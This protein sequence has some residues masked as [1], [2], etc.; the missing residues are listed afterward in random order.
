[1]SRLTRRTAL[2]LASGAAAAPLIASIPAFAQAGRVHGLS[3]FGDLKYPAGF[4]HFD[5]VNPDAP[6]GGRF[7]FQ[8]PNWTYNQ[9]PQTFNTMNSFVSKSDAP[10]RM[11]MTFDTLMVRAVDEP[12][13]LYGLVAEAIEVSEYG[14][15]LRFFLRRQ[16]RFHDGSPLTAKDV[17]FS[18]NIL[19]TEGHPSI[20][21]S[22][23]DM[24]SAEAVGDHEIVV[25][26]SGR[27]SSALKLSIGALPIF[28]ATYYDGRD[29]ADS[30]MEPPLGSGPY[31]VG[32]FEAGRFIEYER[33]EDYWARDLPAMRGMNNFDIIRV[34]FFRDRTTGFE[35]FKKGDI[36]FRQEFTSKVW[37]TE[38]VF[39]AILDGRA[40]KMLVPAEKRPSLQSWYIN[41]RREKFADPRTREAIGLA[42]DFEWVNKNLFYGLYSRSG[43]FFEKSVYAAD[44]MPSAEELVLLEPWRDQLP[45]AV[46]EEPYRP[47]VSDGSGR[48]RTHLRKAVRL[49][50][51]AGWARKGSKLVN[52]Q[53]EPLS[54]EF[55]I[56]S[57]TFERVLGKYVEALRSIGVEA[58]IR[59]VDPAQYQTRQ[60]D[61]DFDII[62]AAFSL[63]ATPMEELK[64]SLTSE[65][66]DIPGSHNFAAIR[67]PVVDALIDK[68]LAAPDRQTHRTAL[69]AID[70]V[71]RAKHYVIPEW[72]STDHRVA[73]WDMFGAPEIK[74]DYAFPVETTWWYDSDKAARI[75]K[76][77]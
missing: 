29:F 49:L 14:N 77:Q 64:P 15:E 2:K 37:A 45:R 63:S 65:A 58:M 70:R 54:V 21:L 51:E 47:P 57:P 4:S 71:L 73:L 31:R 74:P 48:D 26:L 17:A 35:A 61:F 1:L 5:Y 18:F 62:S 75:G 68:A 3:I 6:K 28:S 50:G 22:L 66:A 40:K 67:E 30:T 20:S 34:E 13:S 32:D 43:S 72:F 24:V 53:G 12:D 56:R 44:G 36:T 9:N 11:E 7:V 33:V 10:P 39:P 60:N 19:K 8:V 42:F 27:Q 46:F 55:L 41:T 25:S 69:R 38:Y 59:L 76:A 16:A 23:K 52:S